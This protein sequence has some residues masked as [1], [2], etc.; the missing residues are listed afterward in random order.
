MWG[1]RFYDNKVGNLKSVFVLNTGVYATEDMLYRL[2]VLFSCL[3]SVPWLLY[4]L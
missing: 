1:V 4:I 2:V 3:L